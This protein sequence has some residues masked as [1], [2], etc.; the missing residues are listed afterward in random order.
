[1]TSAFPPDGGADGPLLEGLAALPLFHN[2]KGRRVALAGGSIAAL[3]KAEL[4]Q[5]AGAEV[6]VYA[7]E[8]CAGLVDLARRRPSVRLVRRAFQPDDLKGAA[9]AIADAASA[10]EAEAFR[11]AA[12]AAGAPVNVIDRPAFSDFQFGAIVDRS[13][14]IVAIST[15]G[16]SP[17]LAQALRGRIEALLPVA[18][19]PWAA[20]AKA[21]RETLQ[22]LAL[23]R[24]PRRRFWELFSVKAFAAGSAPPAEGLFAEL[25]AEAGRAPRTEGSV[26]L[27]GAGPGDPE[28]LTL[29]ALRLLQGADV[30]L[31]D[32]LVAPAIVDM[33]R[34]EARKIPVGKRGYKPSCKQN[35][36]I[37]MMIDL[38]GQGKRVVRLKGGDPMVFGRAGEEITEL[39]G[40][41]I[42]IAVVPGVTAALGAAASLQISLTERARARRLQFITAHAHDGRLPEDIDW[43]ALADPGASSV[44]YMGARTLPALAKRL[45]AH[46]IDAA[47]PALL[48]ERATCPDE[49]RIAGTIAS[50]PAKAEALAP[51]GPCLILIGAVFAAA[52]EA[53]PAESLAAAQ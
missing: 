47:T 8:P 1:M 20:A 42:P 27:V 34:R 38:A 45:L 7:A 53:D 23:A 11:A 22:G 48:V 28:L 19:R 50:L 14:V 10:A 35:D 51:S 18:I 2:L 49:R 41:G 43:R 26:A 6:D 37:A 44:V 52:A 29:K 12:M 24:E 31:Y 21:W 13:P 17:I 16:A 4:A 46:G 33:A 32:E 3:W 9:L 36:I 5:A 15:D 40:A 39:R 30:V 25:L